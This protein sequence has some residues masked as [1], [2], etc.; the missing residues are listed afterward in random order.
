MR[1]TE[2]QK[3]IDGAVSEQGRAVDQV[4]RN[5]REASARVDALLAEQGGLVAQAAKAITAAPGNDGGDVGERIRD[6]LAQRE[7]Q[8]KSCKDRLAKTRQSLAGAKQAAATAHESLEQAVQHARAL[9]LAALG[10]LRSQ[11]TQQAAQQ[12]LSELQG[13]LERA[14]AKAGQAQQDAL[15]KLPSY[16]NDAL[17][18]YLLRQGYGQP[19]Y[20][21]NRIMRLL[22]GWVAR[23]V[24]FDRYF[25]DYQRLQDIPKRM[26]SHADGLEQECESLLTEQTNTE[27]QAYMQW[28]GS[29]EAVAAVKIARTAAEHANQ[30]VGA[31]ETEVARLDD[32]LT[33][34]ALGQDS[35]SQAAIRL[36]SDTL[37]RADSGAA[38][39]LVRA[40]ETNED[41]RILDRIERL[42]HEIQSAT[43]Q[44]ETIKLA[45]A[46]AREKQQD[47]NAFARRFQSAGLGRSNKRY[48]SVR[49]ND[50]AQAVIA[51]ERL[52]ALFSTLSRSAQT[53]DD[54]PSISLSRS[55]SSGGGF[56][57]SAFRSG[58]G[59]GGGGFKTGGGY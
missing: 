17:F 24:A 54:S 33:A 34:F 8:R 43:D 35:Y 36:A 28:P 5:L 9:E 57:G 29:A 12:R 14:R 49:H 47:A 22:D 3:I 50:V 44:V 27:S 31:L 53:I 15:A 18:A 23:T 45:Y 46:H 59:S 20:A 26:Q 56:G 58:G 38:R 6:E 2:L 11:P 19:G 39:A 21:P 41:D 51:G 48:S 13:T 10:E 37:L 1:G 42:R 7:E 40:T 16:E 25:P 32:A 52:D 4:N 55:P 30:Q